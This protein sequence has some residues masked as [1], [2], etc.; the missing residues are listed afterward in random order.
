MV[1]LL[2]ANIVECLEERRGA[3]GAFIGRILVISICVIRA[4]G[5]VCVRNAIVHSIEVE[6]RE[7][8]E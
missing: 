8:W 4:I 3:H 1:A 6:D 5:Y 2:N 7:V